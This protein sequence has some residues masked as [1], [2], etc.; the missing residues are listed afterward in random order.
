MERETG[1]RADEIIF[2]SSEGFRT[3]LYYCTMWK[4]ETV[5]LDEFLRDFRLGAVSFRPGRR[6]FS[7]VGLRRLFMNRILEFKKRGEL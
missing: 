2:G 1:K 4:G 5:T 3:I 7:I 6:E